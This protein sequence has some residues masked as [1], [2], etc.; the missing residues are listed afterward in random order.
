MDLNDLN[1]KKVYQAAQILNLREKEPMT[2]I[3]KKHRSLIKK[4]H[5]DQCD[6]EPKICQQKIKEINEAFKVIK[7]YCSN[8]LYNFK[9]GKIIENLPRDIQSDERLQRQFGND[10]LW[11]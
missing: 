9:E 7:D 5:P 4:W 1:S 2:E 8:Y 6:K 10:S 11:G 3:K